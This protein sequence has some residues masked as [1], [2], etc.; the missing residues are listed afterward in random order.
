MKYISTDNAL[1]P[2]GHYSQA[3]VHNNLV[4]ISG[5]LAVDSNTGEKKFGTIEEETNL[6]L[7]NI[8]LILK[9]AGSDKNHVL[10]TTIYIPDMSLW[11]KVNRIYSD[12][13][14]NH[15]PARAIVPT[16]ELHFDFKI[17]IEVIAAIKKN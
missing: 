11:D 3:I 16:R 4:F 7:K 14:K 13:F 12:F 10:K 9:E 17:E 8:D 1:K 2:S 5:Q 15:K 6:V